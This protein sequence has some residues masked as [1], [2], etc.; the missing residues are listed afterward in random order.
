[1]SDVRQRR[2]YPTD[3]KQQEIP[4]TWGDD[5]PRRK[6]KHHTSVPN[7][8]P[9]VVGFLLFYAAVASVIGYYVTW[10]PEPAPLD[11]PAD[12]FSEARARVVL[13]KIMSFGYRP[14]GTRANEELTPAYLLSQIEAIKA[15]APSDV[16]I[17]VDIQRPTGAFGLD[18]I[19]QFQNIYANVTNIV[20]R[21]ARAN[22]T[23]EDFNDSLMI[24]SHYD[25]AIGGAAASDDGVN[26][27]IMVELLRYFAM[28][29]P[30]H[31]SLVFNFNGAEET[32][33]QAA[34]GFITQ[35]PW[36]KNIRAFIN[37]EAA[38]AG[39]RAL[40]FQTG[41]DE[42]AL[43]YAEGAKYPYG[44][45]IAQE[46]FQTGVIPADTDFRVYRDFG[47]VSGMD[48]A[49]IANGYVYHTKLDDTS[50]IQQGSIQ[51][52]G[53]N[54]VGVIGRL[55]N[56]P[57]RLQKV[58]ATP[59]TSNTL[60][61]DIA[62]MVMVSMGRSAAVTLCSGVALL[63]LVFLARSKVTMQQRLSAIKFVLG[64]VAMALGASLATACIMT[65]FAPISWYSFP[66]MGG[67]T[68]MLPALAAMTHRL[69]IFVQ[70]QSTS[71]TESLWR[72]E[73]TLF[74]GM[75]CTY[76]FGLVALLSANVLSAYVLAIWVFFP[77]VGQVACHFLQQAGL[78]SSS[79]CIVI[80]L[81]A[82]AFPVIY[83]G[84]MLTIA[85]QFFIP[86]LGRCG[87][88]AP[89]DIIIAAVFGLSL[90]VMFSFTSRFFCFLPTKQ[91][92]SLR[93][94][95]IVASVGAVVF[96]SLQNPYT[97]ITPKRMTVQH[98]YREIMHPN[99]TIQA[100]DAGVWVNGLDF[101]GVSTIKPFLAKTQ[102]K[103][104]TLT[105]PPRF[106]LD[107]MELYG[108]LPWTL[109]IRDF[110]P[111][112]HSWYLPTGVPE[113][114]PEEYQPS[115]GVVS[116]KYDPETDRRMIHMHFTGPSHLNIFI[117]AERT[118]LTKWSLGNGVE[119]PAA[120][121]TDGGTYIL[122]FCSGTSPS[123][124]HFWVEAETNNRIE[125]AVVGHYLEKRTPEM[126][127][128][129]GAF[130]KWVHSID[131]VSTWRIQTI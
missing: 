122:Q 90:V 80:S 79:M 49:F 64:C 126:K 67:A 3:G 82:A 94:L 92:A 66:Y 32:I 48:F 117:D 84:F 111:E 96:A 44:S 109:P 21:V 120:S 88:V 29:P 76:L 112:R 121:Q 57:G 17:E 59:Y 102:W 42:L 43:A 4:S 81:A 123:S 70:K 86:L 119:G 68:F 25:A 11:A 73:E 124:F 15:A 27:A 37:L 89:A 10:L 40:L 20:V 23:P 50:R 54:L 8:G 118:R 52:L 9:L 87:P 16:L 116:S 53:D 31:A 131:T 14:V 7:V 114:T 47:A 108:D 107:K 51:H 101:R 72:V 46:L 83:S 2:L 55:T 130:P 35:H 18:F 113:F 19:T 45:I 103:D 93:N 6:A 99:G 41:S 69:Y 104:T 129:T 13:E 115:L 128:L 38:G 77:L 33:M 110:L 106:L 30:S 26:V 12:Q 56:V 125:V 60:F 24:S 98:V 62:G 127:E 95:L 65:L 58:A 34:H 39:G 5:A 85:Y 28:V 100:Q 71:S 105:A 97:D 75:L 61:F 63:A 1:M 74:E 22:L 36:T 78:L 91:L